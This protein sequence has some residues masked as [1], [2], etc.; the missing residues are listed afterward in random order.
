MATVSLH[1]LLSAP[2]VTRVIST[3]KTPQSRLQG[4]FGMGAGGNNINPVGGHHAGFDIFDKTRTLAHGRAPGTGPSTISPNVIG[5]VPVTIYRAHEKMPLLEERIFRTRPLGGQWGDVDN[6]GQ[7]YITSQ[8]EYLAQRFRNFREFM[9]SRM[10]RGG[11]G[12]LAS[13]DDWIPV[14]TDAGTFNVDFQVPAAS[15]TKLNLL[16]AGDIVGTSWATVAT[17]DVIGDC[18]EINAAFEQLHGRPLR[19]VWCNS[20]ILQY[21]LTNTG[22]KNA[23]GTANIVFSSWNQ[24]VT[25]S[26]EGIP[27][28]G[29]E[30]VFRALPFLT[31]HVYDAGLTVNGTYTK[32]F[33]DTHAV[34]LPDPGADWA[35]MLEGS[36][37]VAENRL[38]PGSERYGLAAWTERFTQPAGFELIAVDNAVPALY[39]PTCVAY[40][41]V[42]Y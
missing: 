16:G 10:L 9:L 2:V 1:E 19:H 22:L 33:D 36:E 31:F 12:L 4:F 29:H 28:T 30:I 37:I 11:F 14:E 41:T 32:F 26:A 6:R 3:I 24:E 21:L 38:D 18:L 8:E 35:E 39:I 25:R 40:G 34:F 5:H 15:K 17:A 27:G 7:R 23:G 42:V 13:G 20:T